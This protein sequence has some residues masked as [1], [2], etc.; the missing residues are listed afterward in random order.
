MPDTFWMDLAASLRDVLPVGANLLVAVVTGLSV[1]WFT[2]REAHKKELQRLR[3]HWDEERRQRV[4]EYERERLQAAV[5]GLESGTRTCIE[6]ATEYVFAC[7]R[8][9]ERP[10]LSEAL[11]S[12]DV[13]ILGKVLLGNGI[14]LMLGDPELRKAY[15][16]FD[17]CMQNALDLKPMPSAKAAAAVLYPLQEKGGAVFTACHRLAVQ[18]YAKMMTAEG[19]MEER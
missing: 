5:D 14:A 6:L 13:K 3:R 9:G 2:A 17:H 11:V 12:L 16:E 1:A 7:V 18:H 8:A 4:A 15:D 10:D 19:P